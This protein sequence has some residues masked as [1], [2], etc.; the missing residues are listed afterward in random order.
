MLTPFYQDELV[1]LYCGKCE[2]ILPQLEV[3]ADL[4]LTDPPYGLGADSKKFR[5]RV[6]NGWTDYGQSD[7]DK[8]PSQWVIDMIREFAK[9]S[10]IWGGN[11]FELPMSSG[12]IVWDKGQRD[13]SLADGELAWTDFDRALRIVDVSRAAALQDG[14]EHPTQKS[15]TVMKWCIEKYSERGQLILDPFAGSGTTLVAAKLLGRP[16]IGI[17]MNEKY[18]QMIVDRLNKPIPLFEREAEQTELPLAATGI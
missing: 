8:K 10:I 18:C 6:E 1:R 13:F 11:Y 14:K 9:H 2:S 4:C 3:R 17:E 7:W 12:W 16:S 5:G 15:L